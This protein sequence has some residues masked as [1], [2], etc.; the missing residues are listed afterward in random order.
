MNGLHDVYAENAFYR[1]THRNSYHLF[2]RKY[3]LLI[4]QLFSLTN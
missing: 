3:N 4:K 1:K 2:E